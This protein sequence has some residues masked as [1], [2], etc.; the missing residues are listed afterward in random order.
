MRADA[1]RNR[2]ID[3]GALPK[4]TLRTA[5]DPQLQANYSAQFAR[6]DASEAY[7]L[8]QLASSELEMGTV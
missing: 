4:S 7:K 1:A 8:A 2:G 3:A 5:M 6:T